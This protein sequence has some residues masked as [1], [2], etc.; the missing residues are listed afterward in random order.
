M[1]LF[2][3]PPLSVVTCTLIQAANYKM[4]MGS[5]DTEDLAGPLLRNKNMRSHNYFYSSSINP[6]HPPV[7]IPLALSNR[8]LLATTLNL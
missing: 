3:P 5:E 6:T 8:I 4:V 7:N 2:L 1:T